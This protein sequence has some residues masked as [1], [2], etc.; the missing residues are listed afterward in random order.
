MQTLT[1]KIYLSQIF[2]AR[3][4][5]DWCPEC[6]LPSILRITYGIS[7]RPNSHI[8]DMVGSVKVCGD[9]GRQKGD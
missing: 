7:F 1:Q 4:H 9:C 5:D 8:A 2:V 3:D 6:L